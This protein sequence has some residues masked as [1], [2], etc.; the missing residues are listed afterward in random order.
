[1]LYVIDL[2]YNHPILQLNFSYV[3]VVDAICKSKIELLDP[4]VLEYSPGKAETLVIF[5]IL[6]VQANKPFSELKTFFTRLGHLFAAVILL[7]QTVL[8]YIVPDCYERTF[9]RY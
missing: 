9:Q 8:C 6:D 5:Y 1:M 4:H 7:P 2:S 3:L